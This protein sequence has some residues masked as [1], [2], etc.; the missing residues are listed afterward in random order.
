MSFKIE[1]IKELLANYYDEDDW[2]KGCYADGRWLSINEIIKI[3]ER[4]Y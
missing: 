1:E 2:D 4:G 3:I